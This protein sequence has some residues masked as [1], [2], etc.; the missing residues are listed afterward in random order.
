MK[1]FGTVYLIT[2][3]V[4][5]KQYV[6]QT[7]RS[8]QRRFINHACASHDYSAITN[9]IKKY[10]KA[11]FIVEEYLSCFNQR[12]LDIFE[13][14]TITDFNTLAPNGYNIHRGGHTSMFHDKLAVGEKIKR[15]LMGN[16]NASGKR[17]EFSNIRNSRG[18]SSERIIALNLRE[19]TVKGY[20]FMFQTDDDGFR[21]SKVCRSTAG[22]KHGKCHIHQGHVFFYESEYANQSGSSRVKMLEHAQRLGIEPAASLQNEFPTSP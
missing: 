16:T 12:D 4:N 7:I 6:G 18:Q 19:G 9:A 5:K 17:D 15:R 10:G 20:E 14:K 3:K 21:R 13:K 8:V 2:N 11:N 22:H 1:K